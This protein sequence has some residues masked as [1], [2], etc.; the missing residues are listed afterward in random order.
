MCGRTKLLIGF[1]IILNGNGTHFLRSSGVQTMFVPFSAKSM[2]K[3]CSSAISFKGRNNL[4]NLFRLIYKTGLSELRIVEFRG[5]NIPYTL[6]R[7]INS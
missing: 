3:L 5:V 7:L 1:N 6:F 2:G 4:P